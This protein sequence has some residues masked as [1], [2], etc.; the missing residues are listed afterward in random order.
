M[1]PKFFIPQ[2]LDSLRKNEVFEMTKG[3][4]KRDFLYLDDVIDAMILSLKYEAKNETFN[5]CSGEAVSLRQLV[6]EM[7]SKLKSKSEIIFGA[8]PYRDNEVWNMVGDNKKI[9]DAISFVP[10]FNLSSGIEQLI[11]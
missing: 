1:P 8:L 3:E 2:M 9:R 5:V 4:Q 6:V 10:G 11:S 7:K